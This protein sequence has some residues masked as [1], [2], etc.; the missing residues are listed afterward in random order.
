DAV[1]LPLPAEDVATLAPQ[2]TFFG[3]DTLDIR[4]LGTG[5]WTR[6]EVLDQ[7]AE[8]R[9]SGVVAVAPAAA[10][11]AEGTETLTRAY[12]SLFRRTLRS[13]VPAVGFGAA[14]RLLSA[15]RAGARTP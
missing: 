14:W 11:A 2:I 12:G 9:T 1:V 10:G 8:R 13:P 7:V 5:R 6:P 15:L 3:L 4:V